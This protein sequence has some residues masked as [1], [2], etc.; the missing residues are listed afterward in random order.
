MNKFQAVPTLGALS[1]PLT[2]QTFST[3]NFPTANLILSRK[4]PPKLRNKIRMPTHTTAIHH[5][6]GSSGQ[7]RQEKEK[8]IRQ[9]KEIKC[10]EIGKEEVKLSLLQLTI[11]HIDMNF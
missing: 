1:P 10:I 6:T 11:L 2:L 7:S 3:M 8:E 9:E 4:L 5:S